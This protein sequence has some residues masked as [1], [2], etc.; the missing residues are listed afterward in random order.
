[1]LGDRNIVRPW[2]PSVLRRIVQNTRKV[3]AKI[4]RKNKVRKLNREI[5]DRDFT[6]ISQ[7]CAGGLLYHDLKMKFLSPTINLAFDGPDFV[8]FCSNL[9]KYL[10]VELVEIKTDEVSYPVGRL[11]DVEIRFVHYKTFEEAKKK[12]EERSKRINFE[13][14]VVMAHDRDGMNSD[15]CMAAFDKLPYKKVMYTS[16]EYKEY[17]WVRYCPAFRKKHCVGVMTGYADLWGNR[18]YEKYADVSDFLK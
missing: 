15:E 18:Y 13:K 14:I 6:I 10:N 3:S 9:E 8:K 17:P 16:K 2:T 7:F 11:G 4:F 5:E 1:M 12:W